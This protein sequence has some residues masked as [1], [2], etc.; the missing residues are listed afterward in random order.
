MIDDS[1]A[2]ISRLHAKVAGLQLEKVQL[3]SQLAQ[4]KRAAAICPPHRNIDTSYRSIGGPTWTVRWCTDCD[5]RVNGA[6]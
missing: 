1:D 2:E 5:R 6:V 3:Q 4:A